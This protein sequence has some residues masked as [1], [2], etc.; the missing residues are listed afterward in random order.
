[1][2]LSLIGFMTNRH[3]ALRL[4]GLKRR[5]PEY[6]GASHGNIGKVFADRESEKSGYK[7]KV[8]AYEDIIRDRRCPAIVLKM[9]DPDMVVLN[10]LNQPR[11]LVKGKIVADL[12]G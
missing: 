3:E 4:F 1:M 5:N 6:Q 10:H 12:W 8:S 11:E 7:V 9:L 2:L